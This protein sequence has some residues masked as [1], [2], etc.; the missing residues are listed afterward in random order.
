MTSVAVYNMKGGVGK[1][2]TAVSVSHLA[3]ASGARVLLWDLDPQAASTFALRVRPRVEG[4]RRKSLKGGERLSAAIKE[5]DY[6]NLDLLPADFAYRK[7]DRMLDDLGEPARVMSGLVHTI[8]QDYDV[9]ILDCPPGFSLLIEG[10][11]AA[12]DTVLVPTIPTPLSLR[13]IARMIRR[14]DRSDAQTR[15][16]AF[17]NMVDCRKSLHRLACE[18]SLCHPEIF[19]SVRVPC[20]SIV[21][22]MAVRRMP[23]GAYA[24]GDPASQAFTEIWKELQ[25]R[26][27]DRGDVRSDGPTW[28]ERLHAIES[29]ITRLESAHEQ[30][31]SEPRRVAAAS[32]RR[33][34]TGLPGSAHVDADTWV[35]H[36]FDTEP[37]DLQQSGHVLELHE[38][39]GTLFVGVARCGS[40]VAADVTGQAQVQIDGTWAVEILSG[41][42]SPL[43]A[44][45][46][47][48]GD[49]AP[50][51]IANVRALIGERP[52]K[53]IDSRNAPSSTEAVAPPAVRPSGGATV[54]PLPARA[55]RVG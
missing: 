21:E 52:L 55:A 37:R 27:P 22:Q 32:W 40:D 31:A 13:T 34:S 50:R 14:A 10:L 54:I 16:L 4:F 20:A 39:R 33:R 38:R 8:G 18:W 42:M 2:T 41:V 3:A 25:A 5:T 1:T 47:R 48:L 30:P 43:A 11:F 35:I 6:S 7:L 26:I 19:L 45:E 9:V 17:F 15:L 12:V 24:A 23:L 29:L 53:R 46:R 51:L 44:L 49:A 28:A 36:T